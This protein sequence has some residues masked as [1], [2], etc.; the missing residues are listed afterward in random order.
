MMKS[1]FV[2][3]P[4]GRFDLG[5]YAPP[6]LAQTPPSSTDV[7]GVSTDLQSAIKTAPPDLIASYTAEF[8]RCQNLI[9]NGGFGGVV[10]GSACLYALYEKIKHPQAASPIPY[11]APQSSFPVV[12]AA[13]LLVGG[14]ALIYGLTK[15]G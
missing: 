3:M 4:F 12:P 13:L 5:S 9:T 6:S 10:T 14:V 15:L 1:M 7:T 11:L 2:A 8:T